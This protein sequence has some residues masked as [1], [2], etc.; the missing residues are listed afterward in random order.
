MPA[1]VKAFFKN[2]PLKRVR[3]KRSLNR[4]PIISIGIL[5]IRRINKHLSRYLN[6]IPNHGFIYITYYC[7]HSG[8]RLF[9]YVKL[10]LLLQHLKN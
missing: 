6:K 9:T 1:T 3:N 8:T 7:S 10:V 2:T 4:H 5:Y